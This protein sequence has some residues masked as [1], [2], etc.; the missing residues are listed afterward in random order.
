M[1]HGTLSILHSFHVLRLLLPRRRLRRLRRGCVVFSVTV[2]PR[3]PPAGLLMCWIAVPILVTN[4]AR[5]QRCCALAAFAVVRVA[6]RSALR[7]A[8]KVTLRITLRFAVRVTLRLTFRRTLRFVTLRPTFR[9][10]LRS[11]LRCTLRSRAVSEVRLVLVLV[12]VCLV[13]LLLLQ[14]FQFG[15]KCHAVSK[16]LLAICNDIA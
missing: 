10:A 14:L 16:K 3:A 11:T 9:P 4:A 7:S 13:F 1:Q 6:L 15:L 2:R 8:L 12:L 5:V